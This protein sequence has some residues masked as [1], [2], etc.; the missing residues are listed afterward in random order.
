VQGHP[1][2]ACDWKPLPQAETLH[3]ASSSTMTGHTPPHRDGDDD[4]EPALQQHTASLM[5][6]AP[7]DRSGSREQPASPLTIDS[8]PVSADEQQEAAPATIHHHVD[9]AAAEVLPV[10]SRDDSYLQ[11]SLSQT[12]ALACK[13]VR[14][15]IG[16]VLLPARC[17]DQL[18]LKPSQH[19]R[20]QY[21]AAGLYSLKPLLQGAEL[22]PCKAT[23]LQGSDVAMGRGSHPHWELVL[24]VR[25][26]VAPIGQQV[27]T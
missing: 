13:G 9:M 17:T 19:Q 18:W 20:Q 8:G 11:V 2:D 25:W 1:T 10:W 26:P 4:N 14:L 16:G 7:T 24:R 22:L 6:N 27:H 15:E 3:Q 21:E 5:A 12:M 23:L